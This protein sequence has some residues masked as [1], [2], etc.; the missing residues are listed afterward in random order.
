MQVIREREG[1]VGI[2]TIDHPEKRNA[3]GSGSGEM[4]P[5]C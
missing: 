5:N 4:L 3:L 2:L 1:D